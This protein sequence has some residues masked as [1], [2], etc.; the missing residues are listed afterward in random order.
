MRIRHNWQNKFVLKRNFAPETFFAPQ[1]RL[2]W[3]KTELTWLKTPFFWRTSWRLKNFNF[4]DLWLYP[5]KVFLSLTLQQIKKIENGKNQ[6]RNFVRKFYKRKS[7][8]ERRFLV[9]SHMKSVATVE[10]SHLFF[11]LE[12]VLSFVFCFFKIF[13]REIC[14]ER[15]LC[16]SYK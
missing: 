1:T 14:C 2:N 8:L 16:L 13:S 15:Y 12:F 5:K 10:T 3:L 11:F 7:R 9:S 4:R 6:R